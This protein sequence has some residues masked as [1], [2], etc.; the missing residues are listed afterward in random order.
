MR[1]HGRILLLFLVVSG[2]A[3]RGTQ[4]D[5][6]SR[7]EGEL[8][9][10]F[11]GPD[12]DCRKPRNIDPQLQSL[13]DDYAT[14][15]QTLGPHHYPLARLAQIRTLVL[16]PLGA[17]ELQNDTMRMGL[18]RRVECYDGERAYH[19]YIVDPT[20]TPDRHR[21]RGRHMLRQVVYH[22][23]AHTY[24]DHYNDDPS[25][26][27]TEVGIMAAI[28]DDRGLSDDEMEQRKF[29]LFSAESDYLLHLPPRD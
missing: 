11:N 28:T 22:E 26:S 6:F 29:E 20:T 15:A 1:L 9:E 24:F 10:T 5:Q 4:R 2:L 17:G 18:N 25:A 27:S 12:E 13:L 8:R 16:V 21:L 14:D 3:C 7:L 19:I 23:L